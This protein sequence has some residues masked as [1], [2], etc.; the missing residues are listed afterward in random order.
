M[1]EAVELSQSA[2]NERAV[3]DVAEP[4]TITIEEAEFAFLVYRKSDGSLSVST[5]INVP[6]EVERQPTQDE[7]KYTLQKILDDIK[8]QEIAGL[9]A[10]LV[11]A[12]QMR[13]AMQAAEAQRNQELLKHLPQGLA[14]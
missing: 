4:E 5:D 9:T 13:M 6:V 8:A 14:R 10:Q 2:A 12:N 3:E 11:V 7:L 1:A